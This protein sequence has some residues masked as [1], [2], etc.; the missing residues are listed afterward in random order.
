MSVDPVLHP[1]WQRLFPNAEITM[2]SDYK[3]APDFSKVD[4]AVWTLEQA[5]AFA[6]AHPGTTA[7]VPQGLSNPFLLTYLMPP[8]SEVLVHFVNY[9]LELR[10][11]DGMRAREADYWILGKPRAAA[12]PRWSIVDNVLRWKD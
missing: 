4:A 6:R 10:R 8:G 9:W 5:A 1:L 12:A 11:A 7:V 3:T 2:V